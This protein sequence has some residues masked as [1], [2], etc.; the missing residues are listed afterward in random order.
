M[1]IELN[2]PQKIL[3]II[4]LMIVHFDFLTRHPLSQEEKIFDLYQYHHL[5]SR[6]YL[7]IDLAFLLLY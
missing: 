7:V 6:L 4:A 3:T 1:N 2:D 5:F